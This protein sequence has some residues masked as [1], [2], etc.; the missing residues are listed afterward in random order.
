MFLPKICLMSLVNAGL[1][2]VSCAVSIR[3]RTEVVIDQCTKK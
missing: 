2:A 3:Y 1:S